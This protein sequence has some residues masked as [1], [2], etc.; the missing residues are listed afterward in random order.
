M[1]T[2][3]IA[4][5]GL[6]IAM[7]MILS[8]VEAQIPAFFAVPG[9]K[10]GLTNVVVLYALYC[11]GDKSALMINFIRIFLVSML[12]GNGISIA[13]SIAGGLLSG[14]VMIILKKTRK[15]GIVTVSIAGG[16]AH[17]IGQILVAMYLLEVTAIA[18]Y[19][20]I[21]WFTGIVSG[22][23]IGILGGEL[24]KR[25]RKINLGGN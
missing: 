9:M 24:C 14:L 3:Q 7:A 23:L 19:L 20:L 5:Y 17:N 2:K 21:L 8:Y 25:L 16:V 12:F 11:M 22:L 13:Y 15:F 10:L 6:L 18:W 1:K 4:Q